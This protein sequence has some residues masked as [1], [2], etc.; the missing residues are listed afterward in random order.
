MK[1]PFR[2]TMIPQF[3]PLMMIPSSVVLVESVS[4]EEKSAR[5]GSVNI[6]EGMKALTDN[7][8][9]RTQTYTDTKTTHALFSLWLLFYLHYV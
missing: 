1:A 7:V 4:K 8:S 9:V 5:T 3:S 2:I 6:M